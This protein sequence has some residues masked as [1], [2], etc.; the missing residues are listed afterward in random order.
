MTTANSLETNP[1]LTCK[2][3]TSFLKVSSPTVLKLARSGEIPGRR[4]GKQWRFR[5]SVIEQLGQ[6]AKPA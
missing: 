2:E 4:F 6:V 3:V 1:Y 5:K